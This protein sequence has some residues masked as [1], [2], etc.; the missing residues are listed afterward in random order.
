MPSRNCSRLAPRTNSICAQASCEW[1]ATWAIESASGFEYWRPAACVSMR[2][3]SSM[4]SRTSSVS[5]S[6]LKIV[7]SSSVVIRE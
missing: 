5:T 3:V 1:M 2:R 6:T 7:F 4:P